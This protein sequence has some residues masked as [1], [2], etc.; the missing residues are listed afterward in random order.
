MQ[1]LA[2]ICVKRPIF[3]VMLITALVVAGAFNDMMPPGILPS[4]S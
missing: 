3:A 2:Q 1:W 4:L